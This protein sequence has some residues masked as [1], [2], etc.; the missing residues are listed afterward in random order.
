MK[1]FLG[2]SRLAT[3]R[4][5]IGYKNSLREMVKIADIECFLRSIN[6]DIE[7]VLN[8]SSTKKKSLAELFCPILSLLSKMREGF[9]IHSN[10]RQIF[11]SKLFYPNEI[12]T[13]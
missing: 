7:Y 4:C 3:C 5:L 1:L 9:S 10:A 13:L 8:I 11:L 6:F 2:R 12:P